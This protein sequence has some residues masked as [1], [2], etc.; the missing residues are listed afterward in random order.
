MS[1]SCSAPPCPRQRST[2][3]S[4]VSSGLRRRSR[5]TN[6]MIRGGGGGSAIAE[7]YR[8]YL[9][10]LVEPAKRIETGFFQ[11]VSIEQVVR[12]KWDQ[13]PIGMH[14]VDAGLLDGAHVE[15]EGIDELHDHQ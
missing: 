10:R 9:P 11:I 6:L 3:S 1:T 14:D 5:R 8:G 4:S 2:A 12:I 13:S 7:S 15:R